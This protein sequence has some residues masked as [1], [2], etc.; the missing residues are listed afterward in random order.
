[1]RAIHQRARQ[2]PSHLLI[3]HSRNQPLLREQRP[4]PTSRRLLLPMLR[5]TGLRRQLTSN[6]CPALQATELPLQLT[7]CS[8][9]LL[10]AEHRLPTRSRL[11]VPKEISRQRTNPRHHQLKEERHPLTSRHNRPTP[12]L[13]GL[14]H[15]QRLTRHNNQLQ[16]LPQMG[17]C[18]QISNQHLSKALRHQPTRNRQNKRLQLGVYH[19]Q[20]SHSHLMPIHPMGLCHPLTINSSHRRPS[21]LVLQL[22]GPLLP[23]INSRQ[24]P[25]VPSLLTIRNQARTPHPK[26]LR[27][28]PGGNLPP[29]R[30]VGLPHRRTT[31]HQMLPLKGPSHP[32]KEQYLRLISNSLLGL[33]PMEPRLLTTHSNLLRLHP[34]TQNSPRPVPSP[35]PVEHQ[36]MGLHQQQTASHNRH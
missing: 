24:L 5:L 14:H 9:P 26:T 19:L 29:L 17:M 32:L 33:Q 34:L 31:S 11:L 18:L 22:T 3:L 7:L 20:T 8:Q 30:R 28:H 16:T 27:I 10:R 25:M 23:R 21:R 35:F 13:V 36:P 1:M 15:R 4:Q 6:N 12:Q 2:L